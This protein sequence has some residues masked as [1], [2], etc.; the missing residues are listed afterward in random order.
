MAVKLSGFLTVSHAPSSA[1]KTMRPTTSE[2]LDHV[3]RY[4]HH[5]ALDRR[6]VAPPRQ[7]ARRLRYRIERGLAAGLLLGRGEGL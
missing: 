6:L 2:R 5:P 4:L 1:C 3:V 7:P